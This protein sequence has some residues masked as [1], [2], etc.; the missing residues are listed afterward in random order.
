ML[1]PFSEVNA[2]SATPVSLCSVPDTPPS[3]LATDTPPHTSTINSH[4]DV[5]G[6]RLFRLTQK[7]IMA[8]CVT[9]A[10]SVSDTD[11]ESPTNPCLSF[12]NTQLA[13]DRVLGLVDTLLKQRQESGTETPAKGD[14]P[15]SS[16]AEGEGATSKSIVGHPSLSVAV[17]D[18]LAV[19]GPLSPA[20]TASLISGMEGAN[21]DGAPKNPTLSHVLADRIICAKARILL[22][23]LS[24]A[25]TRL[26]RV[27]STYQAKVVQA[28]RDALKAKGEGEG[29]GDKDGDTLPQKAEDGPT[30][31]DMCRPLLDRMAEAEAALGGILGVGEKERETDRDLAGCVLSLSCDSAVCDKDRALC[32]GVE[33]DTPGALPS[34]PKAPKAKRQARRSAAPSSSASGASLTGMLTVPELQAEEA[35]ALEL[36]QDTGGM[37]A[38]LYG[39]LF[40]RQRLSVTRFVDT[41]ITADPKHPPKTLPEGGSRMVTADAILFKES[42][43]WEAPEDEGK[44]EEM[45]DSISEISGPEPEPEMEAEAEVTKGCVDAEEAQPPTE[46]VPD[47]DDSTKGDTVMTVDAPSLVDPTLSAPDSV[48]ISPMAEPPVSAPVEE[49]KMGEESPISEPEAPPLA[50]DSVKAETEASDAPLPTETAPSTGDGPTPDSPFMPSPSDESKALCDDPSSPS[51]ESKALDEVHM[52]GQ[53]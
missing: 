4:L 46:A 5:L 11:A 26:K 17:Q 32:G 48:C 38:P 1:S 50:T 24:D 35:K 20:L 36:Y 45:S 47:T 49:E 22:T 33:R 15:M 52:G 42:M 34:V 21:A 18:A 19:K 25:A 6:K 43:G 27:L 8:K 7:Q 30:V 16:N 31:L 13:P 9:L 40:A 10:L 2:S 3:S 39:V 28:R 12:V 14:T 44:G 23:G 51:D 37:A 53:M 41:M 29:E